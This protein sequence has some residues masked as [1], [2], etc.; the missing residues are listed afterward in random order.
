VPDLFRPFNLRMRPIRI[1]E[2]LQ[3]VTPPD[4]LIVTTEYER[5]GGNSPVLLHYARRHGWSF[6][7]TALTPEL[8]KR[9]HDDF[10]AKYFV[11]LIWSDLERQRPEVAAY[12]R[13]QRGIPVAANDAALFELR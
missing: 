12:L 3:D 4:A 1:G 2:F 13:T 6:D 8:I 11:T 9:L 5:F 10:G 7:T